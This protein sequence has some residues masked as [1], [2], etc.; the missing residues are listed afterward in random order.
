MV[1]NLIVSGRIPSKKNSKK[2]FVVNG[3]LVI[4]PS[5]EHAK[6]ER[7]AKKQLSLQS[8]AGTKLFGDVIT[9]KIFAPDRRAS[10]LTNK[11]ESIMDLLVACGH[12][13]D[14]NWF[15]VKRLNLIFGGVDRE[16][17]RAEIYNSNIS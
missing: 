13:D 16:N 17:P 10:D 3:R 2:V 11:A 7:D 6:W 8:Q 5:S 9:I 1:A 4:A 12:I 14:D 15:V